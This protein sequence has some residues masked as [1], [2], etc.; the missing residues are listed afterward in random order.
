[1]NL[2][3]VARV[4]EIGAEREYQTL[5]MKEPKR[6]IVVAATVDSRGRL[7][8]TVRPVDKSSWT[9]GFNVSPFS[10]EIP[11]DDD[12]A[13]YPPVGATVTV[14]TDQGTT[15][16][17]RLVGVGADDIVIRRPH[18]Q[19]DTRIPRERVTAVTL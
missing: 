16:T 6:V 13:S 10:L 9:H 8:V 18:A 12:R 1:M 3:D 19:H 11:D 5:R 15:D 2:H 17:G 7:T 14:T 4:C